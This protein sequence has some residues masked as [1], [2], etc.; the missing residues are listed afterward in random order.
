[1]GKKRAQKDRGYIT[2]KEHKEEWGGYKDKKR[3]PFQRLP[4]N[5]CAITFTPFEDPVCTED[6]T[7]YDIVHVVP[8]V[9]KFGKHPVTGAPLELGDLIRLNYHKNADGE[10]AC[11]VTSK[12]FTPHTHIAAVK[13]TG[14]VYSYDALE[15]L[16]I[17]PKNWKDLLTEQPFTRKDIIHLQDP[18]NV[19]GRLI[20]EFHHVKFDLAAD[21]DDEA[22]GEGAA[23][24]N[25]NQDVQRALGAL[26][27]QEAA[28]A[29]AAGGGGKRA[30]A[31]RL[32]AEAAVRRGAAAAAAKGGSKQQQQQQPAG[33]GS[34]PSAAAA[35]SG[36]AAAAAGEK[37]WRLTG[38]GKQNLPGFKPGAVTWDTDDYSTAA[39]VKQLQK[40]AAQKAAA[41]GGAAGAAAIAARLNPKA[42][43]D[44]HHAQYKQSAF[45]TGGT[46]RAFTSTIAVAQTKSERQLQLVERNP[47]KKGYLRLHTSLGDLNIELHCDIAPRTTE[48][49][50]YL[51][52][53]GYYNDTV[54]HRSI[55]NFMIQGGDPTGTG[56][57]GESIYGPTFKDELDSRLLHS[58]R[59]ILSMANSGPGT[60]GSQFF[61]TY[62]SAAHLNY[63]HSVFG[64]VVGGMEV[65]GL[66]ERVTTDDEDRPLQEIKI[67][68]VTIFTNPFQEMEQEQQQKQQKEQKQANAGQ[69]GDPDSQRSSWF[70]NPGASNIAATQRTG[71]GKY[72]QQAALEPAPG[73]SKP[74]AAATAAAAAAAPE[75]A[76]APAAKKQ[77][78][79]QP[80]LNFDA[81]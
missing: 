26:G 34:K 2:A 35:G 70:S 39:G 49:F 36:A 30:E 32:L 71:V 77:K 13:T 62:R 20:S 29:F 33:A 73:S 81:W 43:Y 69:P 57:G 38:P 27:T 67:T 58:G 10:Y 17:K 5:C 31:K 53:M 46:A 61:I 11:P 4:F 12:V 47:S 51:C 41:A 28:D 9:K 42:W 54:F 78:A 74:A 56:L 19:S 18:L 72:I 59:G 14:N 79:T 25:V 15:E 64:R 66:M 16:C 44:E 40:A 63:K 21:D 24:R 50:I 52:E 7:V 37:D 68:G 75:V 8:Y 3:A 76:S 80:M 23:L 65:L 22:Q 55:K 48:N 45:T 1:M 6:G 60:N